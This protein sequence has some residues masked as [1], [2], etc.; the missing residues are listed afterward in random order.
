MARGVFCGLLFAAVVLAGAG[1]KPSTGEKTARAEKADTSAPAAA[2]AKTEKAAKPAKGDTSAKPDKADKTGKAGKPES[3]AKADPQSA[4]ESLLQERALLERQKKIL[5]W[6]EG[7]AEASL[8]DS[9]AYLVVDLERRVITAK[10]GGVPMRHAPIMWRYERPGQPAVEGIFQVVERRT[11]ASDSARDSAKSAVA[12]ADSAKS[13]SARIDTALARLMATPRGPAPRYYDP[14]K[15]FCI[16]LQ[17]GPDLW[18]ATLPPA[19]TWMDSLE[20]RMRLW[21]RDFPAVVQHRRSVHLFLAPEDNHWI[22]AMAV[23][24]ARVL[25]IPPS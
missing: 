12:G 24:G 14:Q 15:R 7:L 16:T 23:L 21:V 20:T 1:D 8:Q 25:V 2:A 4:Y 6:E 17:G 9:A 5:V 3:A 10:L 11:A 22:Y 19:Q 13:D 18:L